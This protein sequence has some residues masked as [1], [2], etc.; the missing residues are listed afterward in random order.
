M[1]FFDR[2]KNAIGGAAKKVVDTVKK[3]APK[4]APTTSLPPSL[5]FI[6]PPSAPAPKPSSSGGG[7]SSAPPPAPKVDLTKPPEQVFTGQPATIEQQENQKQSISPEEAL[8]LPKQEGIFAPTEPTELPDVATPLDNPISDI[9]G[10]KELIEQSEANRLALEQAW[11]EDPE[12][13]LAEGLIAVV[14]A[15]VIGAG[16]AA[17][18]S[19]IGLGTA[20]TAGVTSSVT[21]TGP[22]TIVGAASAAVNPVTTGLTMGALTKT[23]IGVGAAFLIK[24]MIETYPFAKFEMAE[25]MD[26]LGIAIYRAEQEGQTEIVNELTGIMNEIA[27]PSTTDKILSLIPYLNVYNA[28]KINT[29]MAIKSAS[30]FNQLAE[31]ERLKNETG[32]TDSDIWANIYA[33][34]DARDAEKRQKDEEYFAD[35]AERQKQLDKD[36]RAESEAYWNDVQE[37]NKQRREDERKAENA[38]WE[39][40]RRKQRELQDDVS[41]DFIDKWFPSDQTIP[42]SAPSVTDAPSGFGAAGTGRARR[43]REARGRTN[44]TGSLLPASVANDKMSTLVKKAKRGQFSKRQT[45]EILGRLIDSPNSANFQSQIDDLILILRGINRR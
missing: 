37:K 45:A 43:I 6:K 42:V 1:G 24:D 18:L 44:R 36:E 3:A 40:V 16:A 41:D 4:P 26:K 13:V 19:G 38:Y 34:Q 29:E 27:N 11:A 35:I 39:D 7:S 5:S 17:V 32:A 23:G 9:L 12:K 28:A 15:G 22:G 25:S 14:G 33:E 10:T 20:A 21:L 31:I 2:I 8:G 30:V